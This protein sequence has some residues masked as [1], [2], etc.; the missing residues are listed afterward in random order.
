MEGLEG[1]MGSCIVRYD[2]NSF[3]N[4]STLPAPAPQV[5]AP[6]PRV[7]APMKQITPSSKHNSPHINHSTI[8]GVVDGL[9]VLLFVCLLITWRRLKSAIFG[10]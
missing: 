4:L 3:F 5:P 9:F 7:E 2:I 6:A 8:I 10:R 1:L